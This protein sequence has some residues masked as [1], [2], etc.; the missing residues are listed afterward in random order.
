MQYISNRDSNM[1]EEKRKKHNQEYIKQELEKKNE[2]FNNMF[3]NIDKNIKLDEQQ[4]KIILTDEDNLMV[5]AGAGTGKTTTITAK[6]NYLIKHKSI[7]EDEILII[8]FTNKA[9]QELKN[10]INK[11]FKH[12][13]KIQTFHK[14]GYQIITNNTKHIPKINNKPEKIIKE[15]LKKNIINTTKNIKIIKKHLKIKNKTKINESE[16]EKITNY[17]IRFINTYK[18]KGLTTKNIKKVKSTKTTKK[19]ITI[20]N[21]IYIYYQNQLISNNQIDYND[22]ITNATEKIKNN[23]EQKLKYKY[24]IIDEYQDISE[25]RYEL[26]NAIRNKYKSK[27]MI[28]GDDWQ[29]I[30]KFAASNINLFTKFQKN[31]E[32][33]EILKIENTYRNS[34]QLIDIAGNF[35]Q[36]NNQQIKKQLKSKKTLNNPIKIIKYKKTK[37]K[38]KKLTE[39]LEYIIKK[40]G[41]NKNILILGRYTFDKKEIIDNKTIIEN[42]NTPNKIKYTKYPTVN[43]DYMTVHS[44]KGLGY[45]NVIL[46]NTKNEK[47]GFPSKIKQDKILKQLTED[48]TTIKYPEERR[49]FYVALT[50]T[51]NEIII[52]TPR[53]KQSKFI[54][55]IKHNKNIVITSNINKIK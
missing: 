17:C 27:I 18:A 42:L 51:K 12:N 30:Y 54:R 20:L 55:E 2:Y 46:I 40:Y 37:D 53:I 5:I 32:K 41:L 52:M 38:I 19:I 48:E 31:E 15:Y 10:R 11:E 21:Q 4:R 6:V 39:I 47:L 13:I 8:T 1:D 36:K 26:I 34:Q 33:C 14:L 25:C 3:I 50:R 23:K 9:V 22:M 24:I 49:L 45:D 44:S 16:I 43:I 29:S 35:I 7:K 28:V